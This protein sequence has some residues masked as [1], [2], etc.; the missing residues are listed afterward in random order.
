LRIGQI[1]EQ[2]NVDATALTT[3]LKNAV[4][5]WNAA[6]GKNLFVVRDDG[7]V[8]VNLLFDGRQDTVNQLAR[9]EREISALS[10]DLSARLQAH[11]SIL[12]RH[13]SAVAEWN[14][15]TEAHNKLVEMIDAR[16]ASLVENPEDYVA[17]Q[18]E[19]QRIDE[20]GAHLNEG[21]RYLV[22][23]GELIIKDTS[24]LEAEKQSLKAR[25]RSLRER[26][27]SNVL[28]DGEH[29]RGL[30]VNEINVYTFHN[31]ETFHVVL[32]HEMGHALGLPHIDERPAIMHPVIE[33][34]SGLSNLTPLDIQAA[35]ALCES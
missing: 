29:R 31:L 30:S 12:E 20:M 2:F 11:T 32:L 34:G 25:I 33:H 14:R 22:R 26:F 5:E 3:A 13:K 35:L 18:A 6:T 17:L 1:D 8:A 16:S 15:E 21:K 19:R 7:D 27:S 28:P 24:N 4:H 9:E 23:Q 10:E